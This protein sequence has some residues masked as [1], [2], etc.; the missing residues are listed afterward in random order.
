MRPEIEII[1]A[2]D[3]ESL[4][5]EYEKIIDKN[6]CLCAHLIDTFI[7]SDRVLKDDKVL[8]DAGHTSLGSL[9]F[10]IFGD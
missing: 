8:K 4:R 9:V 7:R 1:N 3:K 5:M 2:Q 6:P 10:M